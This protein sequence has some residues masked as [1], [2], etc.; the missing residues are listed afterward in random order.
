MALKNFRM[1][2]LPRP[3]K[4]YDPQFFQQF[5]RTLEMY[6]SQLDS[7]APNSA[8]TYTADYFITGSYGVLADLPPAADYKGARTFITDAAAAPVYRAVATGGG[9]IFLPVFS[10]GTN[11]RNG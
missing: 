8:Q 6:F 9:A 5:M 1:S 11:W 3:P 4:D 2:P 7:Q 10:D